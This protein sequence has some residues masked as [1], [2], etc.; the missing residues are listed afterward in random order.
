LGEIAHVLP[1]APV[2]PDHWRTGLTEGRDGFVHARH[3]RA[4]GRVR[5]VQEVDLH[6]DEDERSLTEVEGDG[7]FARGHS[8]ADQLSRREGS[9]NGASHRGA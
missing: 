9:V 6:I 4:A 5:C 7:A 2:Q 8:L 1:L 3:E